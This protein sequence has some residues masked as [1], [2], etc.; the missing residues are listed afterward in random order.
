MAKV[1]FQPALSSFRQDK[2]KERQ[3]A[4][5]LYKIENRFLQ[6]I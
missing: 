1:S 3:T 6:I 2:K 4:A 5:P